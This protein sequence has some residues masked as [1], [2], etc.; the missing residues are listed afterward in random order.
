MW[1]WERTGL[2]VKKS[3]VEMRRTGARKSIR[4]A[5]LGGTAGN[6]QRSCRTTERRTN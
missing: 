2:A 6:H 4:S 3:R 1:K 5:R